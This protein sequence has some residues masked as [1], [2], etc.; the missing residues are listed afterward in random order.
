MQFFQIILVVSVAL[1]VQSHK[2]WGL[3]SAGAASGGGCIFA[4]A[5]QVKPA[6]GPTSAVDFYCT[7][8]GFCAKV[9]YWGIQ[10]W[11]RWTEGEWTAWW[12]SHS[13]QVPAST[14]AAEWGLTGD[15]PA[16]PFPPKI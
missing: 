12:S 9:P 11:G 6:A 1:R 15:H 2:C 16:P 5:P 14:Y 10:Q 13:W 7:E 3:H 8:S 4:W